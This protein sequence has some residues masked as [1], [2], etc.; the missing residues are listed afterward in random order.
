MIPR[1]RKQTKIMVVIAFLLFAFALNIRD[2]SITGNFISSSGNSIP[3]IRCHDSDYDDIHGK[4]YVI[5]AG[6]EYYDRC[7]D[8][9]SEVYSGDYVVEHYCKFD[10]HFSMIKYCADSC[11]NG[12]CQ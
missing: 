2:S 5:Y 7:F 9:S 6:K 3:I 4:G 11:V 1:R 8:G 12:K 10:E